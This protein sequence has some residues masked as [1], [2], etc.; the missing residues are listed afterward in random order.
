[1]IESV[2]TAIVSKTSLSGS[3][4]DTFILISLVKL[5]EK[6]ISETD[7]NKNSKYFINDDLELLQVDLSIFIIL[8]KI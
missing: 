8:E 5:R 6:A 2:L 4:S 3:W 7:I 1:L